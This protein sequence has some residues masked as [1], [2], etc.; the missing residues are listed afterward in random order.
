MS[1]KH[2]KIQQEESSHTSHAAIV[3]AE[4]YQILKHDLL[5]VVAINVLFLVIILALYYTNM[6]QHYLEAWFDKFIHL[7]I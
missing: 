1:K 4:E 6:H 3:G 5:K 7:S 2:K